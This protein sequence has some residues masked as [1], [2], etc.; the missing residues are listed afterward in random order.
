M[1]QR[2]PGIGMTS[3]R[4]RDRLIERLRNE[5]IDDE[6]VLAQGWLAEWDATFLVAQG[7]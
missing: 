6:Q 3:V 4:T 5:G 2:F 7:T 1:N